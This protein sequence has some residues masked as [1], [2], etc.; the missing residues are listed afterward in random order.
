MNRMLAVIFRDSGKAFEG[1]DALERLDREDLLTL[2]AY[3]IIHRQ[4]DGTCAVRQE[5]DLRGF[6]TLAS[7]S[8]GSLIG[9][10]GDPGGL[11]TCSL[12]GF[13]ME[14]DNAC[15]SSDFVDEVSRGLTLGNSALI[16][17]IEEEETRCVDLWMQK[18]GGAIHRC[19]LDVKHVTDSTKMH[20][21]PSIFSFLGSPNA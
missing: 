4:S 10:L 18:L 8:L 14:L 1:R 7:S 5:R 21:P 15:V 19:S 11:P 16:A 17:E 12:S 20:L 9:L 2:D 13:T 3:A 6:T